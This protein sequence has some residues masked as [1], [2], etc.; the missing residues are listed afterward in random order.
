MPK[1]KTVDGVE[2]NYDSYDDD[3]HEDEEI[4][5][6]LLL[7]P[8]EFLLVDRHDRAIIIPYTKIEQV[9]VAVAEEE[10][11]TSIIIKTSIMASWRNKASPINKATPFKV[12]EAVP[13]GGE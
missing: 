9:A 4:D 5:E 2:V 11:E 3:D 13:V 8:E 7:D 12:G 6:S 1:S 10:L